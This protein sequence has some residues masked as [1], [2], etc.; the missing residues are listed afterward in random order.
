M[1]EISEHSR[2]NNNVYRLFRNLLNWLQFD[3]TQA[4]SFFSGFDKVS[5]AHQLQKNKTQSYQT[6]IVP[7]ILYNVLVITTVCS[8]HRFLELLSSFIA[9]CLQCQRFIQLHRP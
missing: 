9:L 7:S 5:N 6:S 1:L 8:A 3:K 2:K 4:L